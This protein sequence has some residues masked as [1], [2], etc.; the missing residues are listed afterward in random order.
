M[1]RKKILLTALTLM[2]AFSGCG[3][4]SAGVGETETTTNAVQQ[5]EQEQQSNQGT[6]SAYTTTIDNLLDGIV[7]IHHSDGTCEPIY[8]GYS[9]FDMGEVVTEPSNGRIAWFRDDFKNI[10]TLYADDELVLYSTT[11]FSEE[12]IYE[13]MEDM[14][15]TIGLKNFGIQPSTR[16]FISSRPEGES[17]YPGSD[18][19]Q[20]Y[21]S[22]NEY[23]IIDTLGGAD[24]RSTGTEPQTNEIVS[25]SDKSFLT[26]C[27]TF[28]NLTKDRAY[29]LEMYDG[30]IKKEMVFK[31][32]V[33]VL[34]SMEVSSNYNYEFKDDVLIQ[35]LVPEYFNTGYYMFNANGIFR[36][37]KDVNYSDR[38]KVD[39]DK[40][41]YNQP[42]DIPEEDNPN[43]KKELT[44]EELYH[45]IL[46]SETVNHF[47]VVEP[48][49]IKV[50]VT[51]TLPF[52]I[53]GD[54][55][56]DVTAI[57]QT[58]EGVNLEMELNREEDCLELVFNATEIGDYTVR[59]YDLDIREPHLEIVTE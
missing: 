19:E 31:A 2:I 50:K 36:Y 37:L 23:L 24:V 48:G 16:Y 5:Y 59:Y 29:K 15:Y 13:R 51:F 43:N 28:K 6:Q 40:I 58:P 21:I 33:K 8:L 47:T 4:T 10:P 32:D 20:I 1:K 17:T 46:E 26:R 56:P 34:A 54:G 7:Y 57:I 14:G 41:D 55:L 11:L 49:A 25:T 3:R 44:E 30:T 9:S 45:D 12:F 52:E 22:T 18:A 39:F 27:G 35:I 38:N 53:E 42:N